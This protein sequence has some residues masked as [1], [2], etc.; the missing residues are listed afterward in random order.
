MIHLEV[1]KGADTDTMARFGFAEIVPSTIILDERRNAVTR[2]TGE[3]QET[4]ITSRITWL[5]DGRQGT[6]PA[7]TLKRY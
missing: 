1:W 2:I 3:A 5:P 7:R 6:P 4:D